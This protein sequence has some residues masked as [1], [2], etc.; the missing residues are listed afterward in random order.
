MPII[1]ELLRRSFG[2]S[3]WLPHNFNPSDGLTKLKGAHLA[4][5]L[6]LLNSGF[7]TLKMEEINLQERAAAKAATGSV[8]RQKQSG[9]KINMLVGAISQMTDRVSR[10]IDG[11]QTDSRAPGCLEAQAGNRIASYTGVDPGGIEKQP[12]VQPKIVGSNYCV[13]RKCSNYLPGIDN[14]LVSLHTSNLGGMETTTWAMKNDQITYGRMLYKFAKRAKSTNLHIAVPA[15]LEAPD[16]TCVVTKELLMTTA[17]T[18]EGVLALNEGDV[19]TA[20]Y[21]TE[22]GWFYGVKEQPRSLAGPTQTT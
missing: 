3:R 19:L 9:N 21:A 10:L 5:M 7:Y 4:P 11:P 15:P 18:M 1:E 2:R 14:D 8:P 20:C 22:A 17:I 12:H 13:W 6:D 16:L